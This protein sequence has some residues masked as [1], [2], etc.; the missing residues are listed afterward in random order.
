MAKEKT[1]K[2]KRGGGFFSLFLIVLSL[3]AAIFFG[4]M[5]F[6]QKTNFDESKKMLSA[7]KNGY[8]AILSDVTNLRMQ[9]NATQEENKKFKDEIVSVEA[10]TKTIGTIKGTLTHEKNPLPLGLLACA[11]TKTGDNLF[12][13]NHNSDGTYNLEVP[14]GE[15]YVFALDSCYPPINNGRLSACPSNVAYYTEFVKCNPEEPD[16]QCPHE[17]ALIKVDAGTTL[18]NINPSDWFKDKK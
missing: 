3:A 6:S 1:I 10:K 14:A 17:K 18:E 7:T 8:G 15:Y 12:C 13:I 9:L 11:E 4:I 16:N 5:Y 2:E